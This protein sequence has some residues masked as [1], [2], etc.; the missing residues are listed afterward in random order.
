MVNKGLK[1][2]VW[3]LA[4]G[5]GAIV[6]I[7]GGASLGALIT[8]HRTWNVPLPDTHA[9]RD[10]AV[11]ARGKY[12]VYGPARCADC[13]TPNSTRPEL[14]QGEEVPLTGG[15]GI[16]TYLGMWSAP[17]LTSDSATGIG[18]VS[19]GQ[20]ARMIR[21]G[22]DRDGHIALPFMDV[23]ANLTERDL[24]AVLSYLRSL[25]PL[26]GIPPTSRVNLMGKITLA[27][28][29]KPYAP[30]PAPPESL[31][32]DTS[33]RYGEYL[34][35][36][37]C[38][39]RSCH[40]ARNLKTGKYLDPFFSGGLAFQSKL[41]PGTVYVSPNLTPDSATGHI[42]SWNEEYFVSR[43]RAGLLITD[44]PMPWGSFTRI[45]DDDL[46]ALYHYLRSLAPVHQEDGP[47]VQQVHGASAGYEK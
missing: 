4:I 40:T 13:H 12:I 18:A 38:G 33:I 20:L 31:T 17:N 2:S 3:V 21:H 7:S 15:E 11:I 34:A 32:E 30:M 45:S 46:R 47:I 16:E 23:Y 10:S 29:I 35:N 44:S 28:F 24:V 42:T 9:V 14:F 41:N 5:V 37:L 25:P 26:P 43:F 36:T 27:Y 19:D 22:V 39:C 6:L 1:V 8:Y